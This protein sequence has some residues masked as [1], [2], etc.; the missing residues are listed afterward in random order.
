LIIL[1]QESRHF[2]ALTAEELHGPFLLINFIALIAIPTPA[3]GRMEIGVV[4][5]SALI[6]LE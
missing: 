6:K 3:R 2:S 1:P 5:L 4:I